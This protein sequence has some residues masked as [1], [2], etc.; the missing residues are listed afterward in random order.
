METKLYFQNKV[1]LWAEGFGDIL[2]GHEGMAEHLLGGHSG[3]RV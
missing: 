1:R 2:V 3:F